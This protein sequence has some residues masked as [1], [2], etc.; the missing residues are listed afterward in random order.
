MTIPPLYK[1]LL[2]LGLLLAGCASSSHPSIPPSSQ[3]MSATHSATLAVHTFLKWSDSL[4]E[5]ITKRTPRP[6]SSMLITGQLYDKQNRTN[7]K[8]YPGHNHPWAVVVDGLGQTTN[9][10]ISLGA[11]RSIVRASAPITGV[12]ELPKT[13]ALFLASEAGVE[14]IQLHP[15]VLTEKVIDTPAPLLLAAGDT[16]F[17]S[18]QLQEGQIALRNGEGKA[19][20]KY[21]LPDFRKTISN[22]QGELCFSSGNP[23]SWVVLD[24]NGNR[25]VLKNYPYQPFEE[26]L[27][28]DATC[29]ITASPDRL[30]WYFANG[31]S[32]PF[33]LLSAG[34]SSQEEPF[35]SGLVGDKLRLSLGGKQ[36]LLEVPPADDPKAGP[37][38]VFAID[39]EGIWAM[40]RMECFVFDEAG[41]LLKTMPLS[42]DL[43]EQVIFPRQWIM[44]SILVTSADSFWVSCAGPEGIAVI[45][46]QLQ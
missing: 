38:Y 33:P 11:T 39:Q 18:F 15:P 22:H 30:N 10:C 21:P 1:W 32:R 28:Q 8:L 43:L 29:L 5:G 19:L 45:H 31:T 37:S 16:T 17:W 20:A 14:R 9:T 26:P 27:Y 13:Q 12:L 44:G 23:I 6:G 46:S 35:I 2:L 40:N 41:V 25:R 34:I 36:L 24:Q 3:I 7:I 4:P 42:N